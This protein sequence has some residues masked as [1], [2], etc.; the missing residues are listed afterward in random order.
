MT[1]NYEKQKR[2]SEC[3]KKCPCEK[4]IYDE[5][6]QELTEIYFLEMQPPTKIF[7]CSQCHLLCKTCFPKVSGSTKA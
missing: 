6:I 7:Q 1:K 2:V 5:I 4:R 3:Y